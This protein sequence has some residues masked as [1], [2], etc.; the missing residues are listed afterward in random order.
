MVGHVIKMEEVGM[1]AEFC[2]ETY[3]EKSHLK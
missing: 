2:E 1:R 3:W